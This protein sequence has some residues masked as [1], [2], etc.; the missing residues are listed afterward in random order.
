MAALAHGRPLITTVPT[1][2]T[3]QLVSGENCCLVPVGDAG[4]LRTAVQ[5]LAEDV[6][7]QEKLGRGAAE[8]AAQFSWE[9]I[10]AETAVFYNA[11]LSLNS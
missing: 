4:A 10:A 11:L 7:L 6:A 1:A 3:P 8:L 9:N 5:A 2:H